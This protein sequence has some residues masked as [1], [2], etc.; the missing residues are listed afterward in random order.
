MTEHPHTL[1]LPPSPRIIGLVRSNGV[2]EAVEF[3]RSLDDR[4]K[5]RYQRYFEYLRD[6]H[7]IK[8]PEN[9]RHLRTPHDT[10]EL[11]ELKDHRNGGTRL[12]LAAYES[13]WLVTHGVRKVAD[14]K[15]PRQIDHALE[16]LDEWFEG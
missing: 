8:S 16:I 5:S 10:Y 3:L 14:S 7:H 1:L 12:Y 9:M 6:G 2:G 4:Q 13:A 11:H 15:V